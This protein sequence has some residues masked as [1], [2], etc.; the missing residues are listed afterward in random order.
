MSNATV[1]ILNGPNL[2]LLGQRQP[3]IYGFL[4]LKDIEA[5]CQDICD[6]N[7]LDMVFAQSNHEGELVDLIHRARLEAD[8]IIMNPAAYT[9]T[10][11]AIRDA[12]ATFD[13]PIYEVHLSNVH[14]R[15]AFRHHSY[16][17]GVATGVIAGFGAF[18]YSAAL[19]AF[20][21]RE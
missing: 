4:T 5:A 9:H 7:G 19:L 17:S 3:E 21:A 2:N 1:F 11:V 13:K 6:Q 10:S 20:L 16:V 15:E 12:L 18:G 14:Q 8:C